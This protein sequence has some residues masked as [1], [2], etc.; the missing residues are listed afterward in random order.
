MIRH[1]RLTAFG[2]AL[3]LL[4]ALFAV[5]AKIA[6]YSPAGSVNTQISSAKLQPADASKIFAHAAVTQVPP[7][8]DFHENVAAV[9]LALL[10]LAATSVAARA[11]PNRL[12]VFAAPG[13]SVFLFFRPPPT[14]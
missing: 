9:T 3:C 7:T 6:W 10:C 5:E 14:I 4:A 1:S 2:I 8:P 11:V 12:Q 13:F